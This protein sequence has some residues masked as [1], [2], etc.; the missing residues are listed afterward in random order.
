MEERVGNLTGPGVAVAT[1]GPGLPA[2]LAR[3]L[4]GVQS[5]GLLVFLLV[6]GTAFS[7]ASPHFLG[8]LNLTNVL[9]SVS[10][11]G[12]MAAVSTL[13]LVSG[14]LDLS[15]G[16]VAALAGVISAVLIDAHGVPPVAAVLAALVVGA[17]CGAV[18]GLIVTRLRINSIITTIGTLAVFRGVAFVVTDGQVVTVGDDLT[19]F[20]GAGRWL[21]LPVSVWLMLLLFLG[22]HVIAF[23]TR[24]GRSL[25]AVG[26]NPRASRLS[27]LRLGPI[28]FRVF[29]ASGL[30]AG[31]AGVLLAGQSGT[32][33]P[34]A[35]PGYELLV[36]TAVL[37]GGTSLHGGEGRVSGTLLGVLIIGTLNNGMTLLSVKT[38]YQM[39]ANGVLLLLAVS[40]DQY[41]RGAPEEA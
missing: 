5:L 38:F 30:S 28:R 27:G 19:L 21:G 31:L 22:T 16:A 40:F 7:L 35:A 33:V 37:L 15:V 20:L 26:A 11:I 14:G 39:V 25:Y 36:V 10:V 3:R 9:L 23:H 29:V 32:A 8:V 18:N 6:L 13:V 4:G 41:R 1:A 12:T 17:L 2:R 34:G 24:A